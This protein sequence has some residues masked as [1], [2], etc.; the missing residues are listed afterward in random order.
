MS[1]FVYVLHYEDLELEEKEHIYI[2][3]TARECIN[4][5]LYLAANMPIF[6]YYECIEIIKKDMCEDIPIDE[7]LEC[8]VIELQ[9]KDIVWDF[10]NKTQIGIIDSVK[11]RALE[12]AVS[13]GLSVQEITML[14]AWYE[15]RSGIEI[16]T[17]LFSLVDNDVKADEIET[18]IASEDF[19]DLIDLLFCYELDED[20]E[21]G[22]VIC[23]KDSEEFEVD[24]H[25]IRDS[26]SFVSV[27]TL[28]LMKEAIDEVFDRTD[29]SDLAKYTVIKFLNEII[30]NIG[31]ISEND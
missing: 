12:T 10:K 28:R 7:A 30:T 23:E 25:V 5:A 11:K 22:L 4:R 27:D 6:N 2:Y 19:E 13:W 24:M 16:G 8:D 21:L 20:H 3:K 17:Y 15:R 1:E 14:C 26:N 9:T 29:I 31:G 18:L